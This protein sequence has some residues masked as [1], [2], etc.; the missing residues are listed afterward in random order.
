MNQNEEELI[1][2][3]VNEEVAMFFGYWRIIRFC[4]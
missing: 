2:G 1:G 4:L 3:C